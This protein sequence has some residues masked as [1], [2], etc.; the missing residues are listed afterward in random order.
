MKKLRILIADDRR[1]SAEAVLLSVL[2]C[3]AEHDFSKEERLKAT[4][5]LLDIHEFR[6]VAAAEKYLAEHPKE[7]F[8]LA[9]V[10]INFDLTAAEDDAPNPELRGLELVSFLRNRF[11]DTRVKIH[12][13]YPSVKIIQRLLGQQGIGV[14]DLYDVVGDEDLL[15]LRDAGPLASDFPNLLRAEAR[16]IYSRM[17]ERANKHGTAG[18]ELIKAIAFGNWEMPIP[19]LSGFTPMHLLPGW[20]TLQDDKDEN[21]G[22]CYPEA[23]GAILE[24]LNDSQGDFELSGN[25]RSVDGNG[26][27]GLAFKR[28]QEL[29]QNKI[30]YEEVLKNIEKITIELVTEFWENWKNFQIEPFFSDRENKTGIPA[31]ITGMEVDLDHEYD[32]VLR[33]NA[34]AS[35]IQ[36]TLTRILV[37]RRI[38]VSLAALYEEKAPGIGGVPSIIDIA[39]LGAVRNNP[40]EAILHWVSYQ[41]A[42]DS[43]YQKLHHYDNK[44]ATIRQVRFQ[45]GLRKLSDHKILRYCL[46]PEEH[47]WVKEIKKYFSH[48]TGSFCSI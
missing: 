27:M 16:R 39:V 46:L 33:E 7:P 45:L 35:V 48:I 34:P 23:A 30:Q 21:L 15:I 42:K 10:D 41:K 13:Q 8:H 24:Y 37:S 2:P 28:L 36:D 38:I 20:I 1:E 19:S 40:I 4:R 25:F 47:I 18:Q 31:R 32:A 17:S 22:F 29:R 14:E 6:T 9:F 12:T 43:G 44:N 3:P 26:Q 11:P 5:E